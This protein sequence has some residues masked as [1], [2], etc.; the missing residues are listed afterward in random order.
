MKLKNLL[1]WSSALCLSATALQAQETSEA[2]KLNKQLR[3][4]QETFEKQQSEMKAS[5]ERM[6]R[7]QQA[8]IDA[9]RKQLEIRTNTFPA[10]AEQ[11]ITARGSAGPG[12]DLAR[13]WRPSDPI[14]LGS[15]QNFIN[16]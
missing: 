2:E 3:Q 8:Q 10:L 15:A 16:L 6:V 9:L 14:R 5:F 13:T 11:P 1:G 7:E 4:L 12:P